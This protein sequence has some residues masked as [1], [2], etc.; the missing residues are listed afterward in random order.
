MRS[1]RISLFVLAAFG[2]PVG[3]LILAATAVG[4]EGAPDVVTGTMTFTGGVAAFFLAARFRTGGTGIRNG[5]VAL[6]AIIVA[7]DAL[8][9]VVDGAL[10]L[11]TVVFAAP[12]LLGC[13]KKEGTAWF[14]SPKAD[15]SGHGASGRT[16]G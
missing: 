5:A 3:A 15:R 1:A 13:L 16:A 7:Q 11:S 10:P 12:I 14:R 2:I 8:R 6:G 9:L 4:L